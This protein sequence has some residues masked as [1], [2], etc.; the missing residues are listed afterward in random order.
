MNY[1]QKIFFT[2]GC[3]PDS[4]P[5][6]CCIVIVVDVKRLAAA[7]AEVVVQLLLEFSYTGYFYSVAASLRLQTLV[8]YLVFPAAFYPVADGGG[9][10]IILHG[11]LLPSNLPL[12]EQAI[13]PPPLGQKFC[14]VHHNILERPNIPKP[15]KTIGMFFVV[16]G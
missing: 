6:F 10:A 4:A 2:V 8:G 1:C 12:L 9:A 5:D 13:V 16:V 7:L 3:S 14:I 15:E 11:Q